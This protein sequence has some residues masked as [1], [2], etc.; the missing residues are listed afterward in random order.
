MEAVPAHLRRH[1]FPHDLVHALL[2]VS[3]TD[4]RLRAS[5][6]SRPAN[7]AP[8]YSNVLQR[9]SSKSIVS[10]LDGHVLPDRSNTAYTD[11][12]HYEFRLVSRS[13]S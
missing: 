1:A 4:W 5:P 10:L 3:I 6:S 7:H 2:T 11:G 9:Y 8:G 12:C 13:A